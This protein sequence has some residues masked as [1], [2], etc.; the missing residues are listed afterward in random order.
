MLIY[1]NLV[2][3]G[4]IA[5]TAKIQIEEDKKVIDLLQKVYDHLQIQNDGNKVYKLESVSLSHCG[6]PLKNLGQYLSTNFENGSEVFVNVK[7][8]VDTSKT[9][10]PIAVVSSGDKKVD[11]LTAPEA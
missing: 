6:K 4:D 5:Q 9:V 1:T 11:T 2:V 10:K 7:I 8:E 3:N